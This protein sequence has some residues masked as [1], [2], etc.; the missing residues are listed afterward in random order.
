MNVIEKYYASKAAL[1]RP[2]IVHISLEDSDISMMRRARAYCV[3]VPIMT[4][5]ICL[6]LR[7]FKQE[8]FMSKHFSQTMRRA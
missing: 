5:G 8:F 4:L 2:D 1:N 3:G 6:L 7:E